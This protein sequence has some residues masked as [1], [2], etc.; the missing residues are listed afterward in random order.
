MMMRSEEGDGRIPPRETVLKFSGI[1]FP[2]PKVDLAQRNE[3]NSNDIL[4]I[5]SR[6][7]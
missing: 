3:T 5:G 4:E 2:K 7:H 6:F 1:L